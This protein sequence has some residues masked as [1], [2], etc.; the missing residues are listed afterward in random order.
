ME[1]TMGTI[2]IKFFPQVAPKAVENFT[3][4]AKNGYYNGLK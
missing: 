4:H 3:T 2:K 1:T